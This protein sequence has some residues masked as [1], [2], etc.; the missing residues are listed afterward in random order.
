M[1]TSTPNSP[2][3]KKWGRR[4][5]YGCV[6]SKPY[7][8]TSKNANHFPGSG[9]QPRKNKIIIQPQLLESQRP[10][11]LSG[12]AFVK[13]PDGTFK[14]QY[15]LSFKNKKSTMEE[16]VRRHFPPLY[17]CTDC[18]ETFYS[19]TCRLQ[20]IRHPCKLCGKQLRGKVSLRKHEIRCLK[21]QMKKKYVLEKQTQKR[22]NHHTT[23]SKTTKKTKK[24]KKM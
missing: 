6:K 13:T 15:C 14:C 4:I 21:K 17:P 12:N 10:T 18:G 5:K 19:S 11:P 20:H 9:C 1:E 2:T 23:I 8:M 3:R 7:K 22:K 24:T 16:H